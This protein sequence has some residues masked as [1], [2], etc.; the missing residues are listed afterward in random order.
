MGSSG[1][2]GNSVSTT[3]GDQ[4]VIVG[5]HPNTRPALFVDPTGKGIKSFSLSDTGVIGVDSA[6]PT[7]RPID[8]AGD[9]HGG[10]YSV[11]AM[12]GIH[13]ESGGGGLSANIGGNITLNSWAGKISLLTTTQ[14][15]VTAHLVTISATNTVKISGPSLYVDAKEVTFTKNVT[16][17]G[18]VKVN[19]GLGVNGELFATHITGLRQVR[20]TTMMKSMHGYPMTGSTLM[21]TIMPG[22]GASTTPDGG[23]APGAIIITVTP[24]PMPLVTVPPHLHYVDTLAAKL[25]T[26]PTELFGAM[27]SVDAEEPVTASPTDLAEISG[28]NALA[29]AFTDFVIESLTG[30]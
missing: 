9:F 3:V 17:G 13:F 24:S 30:V 19:G 21:G 12:N 15:G 28:F 1:D 27:T 7:Y 4:V 22:I 29:Q 6:I 23:I 8:N 5:D 2:A 26:G 18:N 16:F 10:N 25:V 20:P 11:T 14:V